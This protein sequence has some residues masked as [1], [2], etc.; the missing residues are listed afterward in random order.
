MKA[1][2]ADRGRVLR[3]IREAG[4][5]SLAGFASLLEL[6]EEALRRAELGEAD[7]GPVLA[8]LV[9]I[10]DSPTPERMD[11]SERQRL[12]NSFAQWIGASAEG[13]MLRVTLLVSVQIDLAELATLNERRLQQGRSESTAEE[14]AEAAIADGL[15]HKWVAGVTVSPA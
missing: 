15:A 6:T 5:Y 4:E 7:P 9:Q 14:M 1:T 8:A 13:G 10:P 3:G 2:W 11:P 12:L